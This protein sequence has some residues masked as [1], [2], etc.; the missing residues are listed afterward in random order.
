MLHVHSSGLSPSRIL[1]SVTQ[2]G[3]S[4]VSWQGHGLYYRHVGVI[5][6][7]CSYLTGGQ[8]HAHV[9]EGRAV[10]AVVGE[11]AAGVRVL[12]RGPAHDNHHLVPRL[13]SLVELLTKV[14]EDFT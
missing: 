8:Q 5:S 13:Q 11:G 6:D 12:A 7:L 14:R 10:L 3:H 9:L 4:K 1:A 2:S